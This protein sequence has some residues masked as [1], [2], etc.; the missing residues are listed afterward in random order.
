MRVLQ[1]PTTQSVGRVGQYVASEQWLRYHDLG[2]AQ[3]CVV[4]TDDEA[5]LELTWDGPDDLSSLTQL[6]ANDLYSLSLWKLF[7]LPDAEL[8]HLHGLTGLR[9]LVLLQTLAVTDDGLVYLRGLSNLEALSIEDV[10]ITDAGLRHLT[11][12]LQLRDLS[13][14][15]THV[16][17]TG[18][19][20]LHGLVRLRKLDLT[21]T[22]VSAAAIE[23][24]ARVLPRC[25][26]TA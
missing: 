15:Y 21:Y 9:E 18:M 14:A 16:T 8:R 4:V 19:R 1:F 22:A 20:Y 2:P 23:A 3:G 5:R 6:Q 25:T 12:L 26:I 13:L 24:L 17:D 7:T 11:E 10:P